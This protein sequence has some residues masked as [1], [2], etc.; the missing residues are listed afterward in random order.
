MNRDL[1]GRC[2]LRA[3]MFSACAISVL[4]MLCP[5]GVSAQDSDSVRGLAKGERDTMRVDF[6]MEGREEQILDVR[7]SDQK[8]GYEERKI[9]LERRA[10]ELLRVEEE[11]LSRQERFA[12]EDEEAR[13]RARLRQE[14][15]LQRKKRTVE[16]APDLGDD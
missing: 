2:A 11:T 10:E 3:A 15:D 1:T 9:R 7:V 13:I 16:V 6:R 4:S 14:E 5:E 12:R 8:I